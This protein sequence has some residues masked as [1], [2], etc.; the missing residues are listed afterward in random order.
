MAKNE[1]V[2][3]ERKDA[4]EVAEGT[5]YSWRRGEFRVTLG[6]DGGDVVDLL[7][8]SGDSASCFAASGSDVKE[9]IKILRW[10]ID[11]YDAYATQKRSRQARS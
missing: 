7:M 10:M 2:P 8:T 4:Q 1:K 11:V 3:F 5:E 9:V 6:T